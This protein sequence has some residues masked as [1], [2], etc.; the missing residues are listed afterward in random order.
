MS[1]GL[2]L[3]HAP[4]S[5][6][7]DTVSQVSFQALLLLSYAPDKLRSSPPQI[8]LYYRLRW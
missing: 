7:P 6:A 5:L 1:V 3:G 4:L 2:R 8:M